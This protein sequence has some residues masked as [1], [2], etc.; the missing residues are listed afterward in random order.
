MRE[1][2]KKAGFEMLFGGKR[3]ESSDV[4]E[5]EE[6]GKV[7]ADGS[8]PEMGT[9]AKQKKEEKQVKP[10]KQDKP[11]EKTEEARKE[12]VDVKEAE[13][14]AQAEK[15]A[16]E[17]RSSAKSAVVKPAAD[18]LPRKSGY[19][20]DAK[21]LLNVKVPNTVKDILDTLGREK[22]R[23]KNYMM[24]LLFE[25]ALDVNPVTDFDMPL[26][27]SEDGSGKW[28]CGLKIAV[29]LR[30]K[31]EEIGKEEGRSLNYMVNF[32]LEYALK[33]IGRI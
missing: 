14:P 4:S 18:G 2:K 28:T 24:N 25:Y 22:A 26:A 5:K 30:K 12:T 15:A 32:L 19:E 29:S 11:V 31:M 17:T 8:K 33:S 23:S 7:N 10:K 3:T 1:L 21:S 13:K 6:R 27:F 16:S 9:K 20:G